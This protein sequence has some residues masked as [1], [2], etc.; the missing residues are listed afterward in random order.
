MEK[1]FLQLK[2]KAVRKAYVEA[3]LVNGLAHQI[4]ILRQ[5][6]NWTQCHLA[7][8]LKTSQGVVSRLEDP[9]YGKY[10]L[11]TLTQLS[12]AFDV[13]L[14]VRFMTFS[15]FMCQTWD[16]DPKRFEA[17]SFTSELP[18]IG[19]FQQSGSSYIDKVDDTR[20]ASHLIGSVGHSTT[21]TTTM[22]VVIPTTSDIV[23]ANSKLLNKNSYS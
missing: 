21:E 1:S 14:Y 7:K 13:A 20:A 3:E 5:Q 4:R 11:K 12:S 6:R 16:T 10:S 9:S 17:E 18:H 8:R 23:Y 22:I 19:F 2:K 15:Q